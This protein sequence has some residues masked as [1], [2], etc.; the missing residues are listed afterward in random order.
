VGRAYG[1]AME[2]VRETRNEGVPLHLRNAATGLMRGMGYGKDYRYSHNYAADDPERWGPRYLPE[3]LSGRR[4][5]EPGAQGFEADEI[6]PRL[7]AERAL[8][9]QA[10]PGPAA[11]DPLGPAFKE[12]GYQRPRLSPAATRKHPPQE[13]KPH[14]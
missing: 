10:P 2:A 4:F 1:A 12:E 13:P 3:T 8:G 11:A 14:V 9:E 6:A 5:Y 7:A